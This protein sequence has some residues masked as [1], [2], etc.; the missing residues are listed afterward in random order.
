LLSGPNRHG[1]EVSGVAQGHGEDV[2][3]LTDLDGR[4]PGGGCRVVLEALT[5]GGDVSEVARDLEIDTTD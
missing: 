5:Q 1:L 4:L 2:S 3:V